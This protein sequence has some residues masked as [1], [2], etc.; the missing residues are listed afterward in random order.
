MAGEGGICLTALM[1][2][3]GLMVVLVNLLAGAELNVRFFSPGWH[4]FYELVRIVLI[5]N[6]KNKGI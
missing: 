4:S 6:M 3:I 1:G 5:L 2:G